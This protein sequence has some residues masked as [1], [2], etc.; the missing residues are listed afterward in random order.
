[1]SLI[2]AVLMNGVIDGF[3]T[4]GLYTDEIESTGN[5]FL[6]AILLFDK[7][8]LFIAVGFIISVGLNFFQTSYS[9]RLFHN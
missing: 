2:A 8:I 3:T 6:S 9:S 7:V 5:K 4:A 1:M